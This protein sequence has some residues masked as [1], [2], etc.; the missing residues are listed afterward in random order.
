MYVYLGSVMLVVG[1]SSV[2]T[3]PSIQTHFQIEQRV[4]H[5]QIVCAHPIQAGQCMVGGLYGPLYRWPIGCN[6][7]G[8]SIQTLPQP[9]LACWAYMGGSL[10]ANRL[11]MMLKHI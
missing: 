4:S 5:P 3:I 2:I 11:A 7:Q 10:Q 9:Q 8:S 1:L 6:Y